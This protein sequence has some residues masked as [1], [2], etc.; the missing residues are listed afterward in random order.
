MALAHNP[1]VFVIDDDARIRAS[2]QGLL[3]FGGLAV[4]CS[5]QVL[6]EEV[7]RDVKQDHIF[8]EESNVSG[9]RGKA[10]R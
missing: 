10:A 4:R 9:H 6:F 2:I 8:H 5:G 7:E 3:K 1:T